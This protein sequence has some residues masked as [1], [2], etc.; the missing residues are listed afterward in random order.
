VFVREISVYKSEVKNP[1]R[2]RVKILVE[3]KMLLDWPSLLN[4]TL[5]DPTSTAA[6][7]KLCTPFLL[8]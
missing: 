1:M 2:I 7:P 5:Q 6:V 8:V 4:I 3:E